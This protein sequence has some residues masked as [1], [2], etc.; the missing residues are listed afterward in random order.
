M[1]E[2]K[3]GE[4]V[5][6][7]IQLGDVS[8]EATGVVD[9]SEID[10]PN[11]PNSID[12]ET[13]DEIYNQIRGSIDLKSIS[14]EEIFNLVDNLVEYLTKIKVLTGLEKKDLVKYLIARLYNEIPKSNDQKLEIFR[15]LVRSGL[16]HAID[17]AYK[18]IM[19]IF[20]INKDGKISCQECKIV[21]SRWCPCCQCYD[22]TI[23]K[24]PST[25]TIDLSDIMTR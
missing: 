17:R 15:L 4:V 2:A 25:S 12:T 22:S 23:D 24:S 9:E 5:V 13:L 7:D 11:P 10:V 20:D 21:W 14:T 19:R 8:I 18:F 3:N 6:V 16:P 1:S